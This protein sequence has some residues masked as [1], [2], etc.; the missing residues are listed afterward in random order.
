MR[1][2]DTV[3]CKVTRI[4]A[5]GVVVALPDR[6]EGL[7]H[8]SELASDHIE[9][10]RE[11]VAIGERFKAVAL[12]IDPTS[13]A[14]AL[15]RKQAL[16]SS[17]NSSSQPAMAGPSRRYRLFLP[18]LISVLLTPVCIGWAIASVG[19]GHG[20][21]KVM[22]LVYPYFYLFDRPAKNES[23]AL[24]LMGAELPIYGFA[25]GLSWALSP[26]GDWKFPGL[27]AFLI[28]FCHGIA[29]SMAIRR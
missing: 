22:T 12:H 27:M 21:G 24:L 26:K 9:H 28:A 7:I 11:V 15:S 3:E 4:H 6:S 5:V 23:I 17:P 10:P 19:A 25:I 29:V 1:V 13:R 16:N 2:G 8:V 20:G 18:I 14:W